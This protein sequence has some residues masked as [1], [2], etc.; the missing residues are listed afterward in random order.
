MGGAAATHIRHAR[1]HISASISAYLRVESALLHAVIFQLRAA[2]RK[3]SSKAIQPFVSAARV[4]DTREQVGIATA[5]DTKLMV[6]G[7]G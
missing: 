6:D 3:L 5:T 1:E 4:G 2:F 7:K